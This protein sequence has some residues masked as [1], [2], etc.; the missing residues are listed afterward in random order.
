VVDRDHRKRERAARHERAHQR[1]D[2]AADLVGVDDV[3]Q[4]RDDGDRD[5]PGQ[6]EP[7]ADLDAKCR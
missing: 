7:L 3:T 5:R 2:D 6:L 1:L 4:H